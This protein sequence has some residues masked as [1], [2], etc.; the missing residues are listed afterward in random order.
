MQRT[1][2]KSQALSKI[3]TQRAAAPVWRPQMSMIQSAAGFAAGLVLAGSVSNVTIVT[4]LAS[5]SL[6]LMAFAAALAAG[7]GPRV[8]A[9]A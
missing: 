1:P 3:G 4:E 9:T 2:P 6:M 7:R 5:W 8:R